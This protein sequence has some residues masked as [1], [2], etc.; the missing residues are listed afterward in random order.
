MTP[1]ARPGRRRAWPAAATA[2]VA[3][4][5]ALAVADYRAWE[6][7]QRRLAELAQETG[8]LEHFP[9]LVRAQRREFHVAF[10]RLG[11]AR[12]LLALEL[13]RRWLADLPEAAREAEVERGFARLAVA[14]NL[15]LATLARQPGA[16]QAAYVL[17]GSNYLALSRRGDPAVRA[18]PALWED[19]LLR[20][21]DLAPEQPEPTRL[22]AAAYLGN[23]SRMGA[24]ERTAATAVVA[25]AL[26]NPSSFDLLMPAWL[27]V[28]PSLDAA[29]AVVPDDPRAW[30]QLQSLF[31][32]R[33]DLERFRDATARLEASLPPFVEA[34]L[35]EA[36]SLLARGA[37]KEARELLSWQISLLRP[38]RDDAP[39]FERA[40][41]LLPPGPVAGEWPGA[42]VGWAVELAPFGGSPLPQASLSR[43][44]GLA[45]QLP[46]PLA[47]AAA[48]AAGDLAKGQRL[49][50]A[51]AP[52][53]EE[54]WALYRLLA[55][56]ELLRR[57][58]AAAAAP[59]LAA[60]TGSWGR[61]PVAW[62]ARQQAAA[63]LGDAAG[64]D[65]AQAVLA[66]SAAE[67]WP[68]AAWEP[69]RRPRLTV[70]A[71]S[72]GRL[73][74]DL[75]TDAAGAVVEL[76]W[77][78]KRQGFFAARPGTTVTLDP[79]LAGGPHALDVVS[80]LGRSLQPAAARL[81]PPGP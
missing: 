63:A 16:W 20:A 44:A 49:E 74:V 47:A 78:G 41:A 56:Q 65:R 55:G 1:E 3:L 31:A 38:S 39:L 34:R 76:L 10:A 18:N 45:R 19:L 50:R 59:T 75:E 23:W 12:A 9:G 62:V 26:R 61:S 71:S 4:A 14:R 64:T 42:W 51:S 8:A 68:A 11:L 57:G 25:E 53:V 27:R 69:G 17:G 60:V 79:D 77:D 22:L 48:V 33:G 58:D 46:A 28:A 54:S 81:L 24:D 70:L 13:D 73:A 2:A 29:L 52:A 72:P 35:A 67:S 40:L 21:R 30:L 43:L 7:E 6:G 32:G 80:L 15:A 37:T 66:A 5:A 36:A